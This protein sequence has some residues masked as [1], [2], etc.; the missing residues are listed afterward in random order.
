MPDSTIYIPTEE[1]KQR[2]GVYGEN[3]ITSIEHLKKEEQAFILAVLVQSF[4]SANNIKIN[5]LKE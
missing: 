3:I 1:E 4:E 2:L 5:S